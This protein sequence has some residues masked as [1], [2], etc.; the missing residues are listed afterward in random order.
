[1]HATKSLLKSHFG[2]GNGYA[3]SHSYTL[4]LGQVMP[5]ISAAWKN[6]ESST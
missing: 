6:C 2:K 5:L 3:L 4:P 1:M